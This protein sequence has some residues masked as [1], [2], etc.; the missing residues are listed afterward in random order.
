MIR[1]VGQGRVIVAD[2][3]PRQRRMTAIVLR[4]AG[5]D[6]SET[7]QGVNVLMDGK[8]GA[9]DA[10]VT[11]T[12]LLDG[13]GVDL[14]RALRQQDETKSLP[15]LVLSDEKDRAAE[16]EAVLGADGFMQKPA[17]PSDLVD[18]VKLLL[19]QDTEAPAGG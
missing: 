7:G 9:F 17:R 10:V 12:R 13:D 3:D 16:V 8:R 19:G 2:A 11:E 1:A 15:V 6:V 18:R 14:A 5:Y 4:L